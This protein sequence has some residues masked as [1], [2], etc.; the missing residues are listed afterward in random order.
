MTATTEKATDI[1]TTAVDVKVETK[2]EKGE[3]KASEKEAASVASGDAAISISATATAEKKV[4]A[5]AVD[6]KKKDDNDVNKEKKGKDAP[7]KASVKAIEKPVQPDFEIRYHPKL[8]YTY[9]VKKYGEI[10]TVVERLGR[11]KESKGSF[12]KGLKQ[13]YRNYRTLWPL[14][15]RFSRETIGPLGKRRI[16][17]CEC[18]TAVKLS[19]D[20]L[21]LIHAPVSIQT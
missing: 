12:I 8:P 21:R 19:G 15:F 18:E 3:Q 9:E 17:C 5:T 1:S 2:L 14:F 20:R 7:L 10:Y 11:P 16:L 6:E 4:D 13:R